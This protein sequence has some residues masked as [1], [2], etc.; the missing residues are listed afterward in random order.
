MSSS[1]QTMQAIERQPNIVLMFGVRWVRNNNYYYYNGYF[2]VLFL[3]RAHSPLNKKNNSGLN[4]ELGKT[5][6]L[7]ALCMMEINA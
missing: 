4:I 6:R 1:F 5:N 3:R 7:K 2:K